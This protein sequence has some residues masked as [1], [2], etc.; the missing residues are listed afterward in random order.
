MN[1]RSALYAAAKMN[2]IVATKILLVNLSNAFA[3]D[4]FGVKIEHTTVNLRI[5]KLLSMG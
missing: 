4:K 1:G 5:L 3:I 2:N